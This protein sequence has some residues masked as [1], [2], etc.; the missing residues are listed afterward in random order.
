MDEWRI[1]VQAMEAGQPMPDLPSNQ[2]TRKNGRRKSKFDNDDNAR[3]NQNQGGSRESSNQ[4]G[5]GNNVSNSSGRGKK[6][7]FVGMSQAA[8]FASMKEQQMTAQQQ[9]HPNID[10]ELAMIDKIN[11]ELRAQQNN[12]MMATQQNNPMM[13]NNRMME[14]HPNNPFHMVIN[15]PMMGTQQNNPMM[16]FSGTNSNRRGRTA[17]LG[18]PQMENNM[19]MAPNDRPPQ[20]Y[21][22][23]NMNYMGNMMNN[24][25]NDMNNMGNNMAFMGSME[26]INRGMGNMD[27]NMSMNMNALGN[28]MDRSVEIAF[29]KNMNDLDRNRSSD[30]DMNERDLD[31][32][33]NDMDRNRNDIDRNRNDLERNRN[34]MDRNRN[35]MDRNRRDMDRNRNDLD[36]NRRDVDR[37]RRS[38]SER[39]QSNEDRKRSDA[40]RNRNDV[41]RNRRSDVDRNRNDVDGQNMDDMNRNNDKKERKKRGNE[42]Y[43]PSAP[44]NEKFE[45]EQEILNRI[46]AKEEEIRRKY[47]AKV[48]G[49]EFPEATTSDADRDGAWSSSFSENDSAAQA[50]DNV[51]FNNPAVIDK[52]NRQ[53]NP[54]ASGRKTLLGSAPNEDMQNQYGNSSRGFPDQF[55][56]GIQDQIN[57]NFGNQFSA[58]YSDQYGGQDQFGGASNVFRDQ[59][60]GG[61]GMQTLMDTMMNAAATLDRMGNNA[62]DQNQGSISGRVSMSEKREMVDLKDELRQD[63]TFRREMVDLKDELRQ[64]FTFRFKDALKSLGP[65]KEESVKNFNWQC[66]RAEDYRDIRAKYLCCHDC[67]V[68]VDNS[69]SFMRHVGGMKHKNKM[70]DIEKEENSLI[71]Q[72]RREVA[73]LEN[74]SDDK[75]ADYCA[76]CECKVQG[77]IVRHR[78]KYTHKSLKAYIHPYCEITAKEYDSRPVYHVNKFHPDYIRILERERITKPVEPKGDTAFKEALQQIIESNKQLRDHRERKEKQRRSKSGE[79]EDKSTRSTDS[80]SDKSKDRTS[81]RT[82]D[83]SSDRTKDRSSDRSKDRSSDKTKDRSSDKKD[84]D[85]KNGTSDNKKSSPEK[86]NAAQDDDDDILEIVVVDKKEKEDPKPVSPMESLE[87]GDLKTYDEKKGVGKEFLRPVSGFFC[88]VC[89]K[90]LH[91]EDESV[92]HLKSKIH[93]DACVKAENTTQAKKRAAAPAASKDTPAEK[94][95]KK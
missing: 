15:N 22:S 43:S 50:L 53:R 40:D 73:K 65:R 4:R 46:R 70:I 11:H 34:D 91:T 57:E 55:G 51:V 54:G 56:A 30:M 95:L 28:S 44:T 75:N 12:P 31:R 32:N 49:I 88:K 38:D 76:L 80:S 84:S 8:A 16:E 59:F 20:F 62:W 10:E 35:D 6:P 69:E 81:D 13:S 19:N 60:G 82:K 7:Q 79:K 5:N 58:G 2:N 1:A 78:S 26:N 92:S 21:D 27:S 86:K 94:L 48:G 71:R 93:W 14:A 68:K 33:R 39:Y 18:T 25:G 87:I 47:R 24:M 83:R 63:I 64:D 41:D 45:K 67:D 61:N 37:N 66:F 36:K 90:L 23:S 74:A 77:D 3:N 42:R 9:Q 29:G 89:K 52:I 17:L 72:Y 85:S